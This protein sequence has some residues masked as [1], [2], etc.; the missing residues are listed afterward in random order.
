VKKCPYC[1]E[2]IQDEAIK[3]RYCGSDLTTPAQVAAEPSPEPEQPGGPQPQGDQLRAGASDA[4]PTEAVGFSHTGYRYL[5]GHGADFFGIWDRQ[6]PGPPIQR[7]PRTDEG[8]GT[9]W[10][11]FVSLEPGG[12]PVGSP[13]GAP[14]GAGGT[15]GPVTSQ[16]YPGVASTYEAPQRTNGMAIASLVLGILWLYWIGSILALIFGYVAKSEI[17]RSGGRETGRGLA[18]AGIVLG[19]IGVAGGV[20]FIIL[21]LVTNTSTTVHFS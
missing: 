6:A 20:I 12:Q 5:L 10:Q 7:Y 14:V 3:C 1:A 19:W 17:D 16:Q 11:H 13:I 9:A 8:W 18:I 4:A 21:V 15:G 2:E